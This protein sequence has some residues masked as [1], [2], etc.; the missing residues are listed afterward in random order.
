MI[1]SDGGDFLGTGTFKGV[2]RVWNTSGGGTLKWTFNLHRSPIMAIKFSPSSLLLASID[3]QR[4]IGLWDLRG[5]RMLKALEMS[6][7]TNPLDVEWLSDN[8]F[9]VVGGNGAVESFEG[10]NKPS[11]F[12]HEGHDPKYDVT[13]VKWDAEVA[14][15]ATAGDDMKIIL[16]KQRQSLPEAILEGHTGPINKLQWSSV[17]L[18]HAEP[19][20]TLASCSDDGTVRIWDPLR[21]T[22]LQVMGLG[23]VSPGLGA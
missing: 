15:F 11:P 19:T 23:Q 12:V 22:C 5:G 6:N 8:I 17:A 16:W 4:Y 7:T 1:W 10:G 20:T 21:R 13:Q 18:N 14:M 2:I 9:V 3:G